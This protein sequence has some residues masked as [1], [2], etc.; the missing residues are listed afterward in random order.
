MSKQR[1]LV[2]FSNGAASAVTAKIAIEMGLDPLI[3]TCDTKVNE[4][5]D[6]IRFQ[7]DVQSWLGREI[8]EI[9]SVKYATVDDVFEARKYMSGIGGAPCTTE[10]KKIPRQDFQRTTTLFN[11]LAD[12]HHFGYTVE[13]YRRILN[14]K[15]NNPEIISRFPLAY[16]GLTKGDCHKR[17]LNAGIKTPV[18]YELGFNN[19]NCMGCVKAQSPK[20]W[21]LTRI[22]FPEVFKRRCEQSRKLGVRLVKIGKKRIFL[23]E[24]P[25][26]NMTDYNEQIECGVACQ[27]NK[28]N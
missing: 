19:N 1:H 3:V 25:P 24:L 18:M 13:E 28:N 27:T 6:N 10:L 7:N 20:Y 9:K 21:N 12:V 2:W 8:I 23:D 11:E 15:N 17:I 22:H 5:P 26:D 16:Y 14:F 4:H